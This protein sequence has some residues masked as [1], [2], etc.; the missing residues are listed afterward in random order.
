LGLNTRTKTPPAT[1]AFNPT[2]RARSHIALPAEVLCGSTRSLAVPNL[3]VARADT[4]RRWLVVIVLPLPLILHSLKLQRSTSAKF[5]LAYLHYGET[6][7]HVSPSQ[8]GVPLLSHPTLTP[9]SRH[10]P[11]HSISHP[12]T[13]DTHRILLNARFTTFMDQF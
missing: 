9:C 3:R 6:Y 8:S 1:C 4:G 5:S 12:F 13:H 10:S 2:T 11:H 7:T